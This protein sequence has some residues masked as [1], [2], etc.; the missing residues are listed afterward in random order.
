MKLKSAESPT[1]LDYQSQHELVV[2]ILV[3]RVDDDTTQAR[4]AATYVPA[5]F[6]D[7]PWSKT[8]GH[9]GGLPSHGEFCAE[10]DGKRIPLRPDG[11][12]RGGDEVST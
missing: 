8:I 9:C 3:G 6:A 12:L 5:I 4:D 11:R 2:R 1:I 10:R 7:N